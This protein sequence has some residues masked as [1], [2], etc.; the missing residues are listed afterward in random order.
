M[1]LPD[2]FS[3]CVFCESENED[4]TNLNIDLVYDLIEEEKIAI[5]NWISS[6]FICKNCFDAEMITSFG[7]AGVKNCLKLLNQG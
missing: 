4:R 1:K 5:K 3:K 7:K 2:N 6:S